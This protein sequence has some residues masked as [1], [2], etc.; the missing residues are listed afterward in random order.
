[1]KNNFSSVGNIINDVLETYLRVPENELTRI[2]ALWNS[3]V[4]EV[5]AKNTTP[6]AIKGNTLLINAASST[7]IHQ[8]QFM[9][10]NII[11]KIN[12]MLGKKFVEEIIF[13]I[14]PV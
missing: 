2:C 13:K 3:T 11:S 5:V 4:G 14:G 10:N 6:V 12:R 7:W 9:K 8:L 1:M